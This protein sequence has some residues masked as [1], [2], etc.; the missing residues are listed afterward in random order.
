MHTHTHTHTLYNTHTHC[1]THKTTVSE[2]GKQARAVF[3]VYEGTPQ[4]SDGE[5]IFCVCRSPGRHTGGFAVHQGTPQA[6]D[7]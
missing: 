7:G 6:S 1:T 5:G 2:E 3:A 4:T